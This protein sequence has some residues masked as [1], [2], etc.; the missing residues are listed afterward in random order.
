MAAPSKLDS[1]L[2][3]SK[4]YFTYDPIQAET[5]I[6][7]SRQYLLKQLENKKVFL[8]KIDEI[9]EK[10]QDILVNQEILDFIIKSF[11]EVLMVDTVSKDSNFFFDLGGSSLDYFS[12]I[13]LLN[14]HFNINITFEDE[15]NYHTPLD[16]ALEV[17]RLLSL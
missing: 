6:K 10:N 14:Q 9:K 13:S 2:R 3:V 17:E 5:A 7:V 1:S 8:V 12:L 11:K 4:I 15:K 16:L